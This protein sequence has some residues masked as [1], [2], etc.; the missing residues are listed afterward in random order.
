MPEDTLEVV[1][2]KYLEYRDQRRGKHDPTRPKSGFLTVMQRSDQW[3]R[4][5]LRRFNLPWPLLPEDDTLLVAILWGQA[6]GHIT[7]CND[8]LCAAL[9]YARNDLVNTKSA[10]EL[11]RGEKPLRDKHTQIG[12]ASCRE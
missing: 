11:L 8:A 9:R 7:W 12:R 4:N 1:F 5:Y 6:P 2:D 3:L 10:Q